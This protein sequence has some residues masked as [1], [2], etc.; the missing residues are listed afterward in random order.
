MASFTSDELNYIVFR[1]LRESGFAH[2]AFVLGCEAGI[3]KC[4]IDGNL[5]P[6]GALITFVQKGHQYMEMEA[7]LTC[8][9][10]TDVDEDFSFLQSLDL[11][12]KDA[13]ELW[14][15]VKEKKKTQEKGKDKEFDSK[16]EGKVDGA[17]ERAKQ[18]R[19]KEC[20]ND[21]ERVEKDKGREK[22]HEDHPDS[23]ISGGLEPVD[24]SITSTYH[25]CKISSPD[26]IILEGH[27]SEVC[28]C[29]WS[30]AG[31]LL[32]S[33]SGDSTARI[34]TIGDEIR[35]S[36]LQN[37]PSVLVLKH[38]EG[39]TNENGK[40]VLALDW[41]EDGTLLA[42]GCF[43]GRTTI[44][45]SNGEL[46]RILEKHKR[47]IL[48][49][50]WNKKGDYL[51]TGSGDT[52]AI[53]WDVKT[54][55]QIQQFEVH[56]G[57]L[58]DVDW[59]N[60]VSFATSS[61]DKM[62]YVC[63]IGKTRPIR[64]FSGHQDEVNCVRWNP[65]GSLLA[66]C[67][68]DVTAKIWSMKQDKYVH[69]LRDHAKEIY[70]ISWSPTGSGTNNPNQ[71]LVLASASFDSTVKL[72]GVEEGRLLC[73]LNGHR[74]AVYSVAFSPNGEYLASGSCD[75]S[76]HIWSVKEGKIVKTYTGNGEIFQ[77]CWNKE[78]DKIAACFRDSTV[79]VMDFRM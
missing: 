6:L 20:E 46:T 15:M 40:D 43:D 39:E 58:L 12:T 2:S 30:P 36:S 7:N 59:R 67:S 65:M 68:D 73:S 24:T 28:V 69:D 22:Q 78:G 10:D 61:T 45:S 74:D 9:S 60:N 44:W 35:R 50:K 56:S 48:S 13:H 31:S 64:T 63:K 16:Y 33:G 47:S 76:M 54:G 53:V 51:L 41:N 11:I 5:V 77:V 18:Y 75:K 34:W 72:W 23:G 27:T 70:T 79:C 38:F 4:S 26:V 1:Y 66:S 29:A 55:K 3:D 32:A 42:T 17:R 8:Q 62:I 21:K 49:L 57:S 37:H 25:I 19:E 14:Q 52:T 71:Q